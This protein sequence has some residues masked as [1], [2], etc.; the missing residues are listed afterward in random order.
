MN[1]DNTHTSLKKNCM[2]GMENPDFFNPQRVSRLCQSLEGRGAQISP[3]KTEKPPP[4]IFFER[5]NVS[6]YLVLKRSSVREHC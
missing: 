6:G 2:G 4:V 3:V 1:S 5:S